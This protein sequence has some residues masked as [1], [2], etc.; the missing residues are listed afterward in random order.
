MLSCRHSFSGRWLRFHQT[1][2]DVCQ[3]DQLRSVAQCGQHTALVPFARLRLASTR[4]ERALNLTSVLSLPSARYLSRQAATRAIPS[5]LCPTPRSSQ[6]HS[7]MADSAA[8]LRRST[9]RLRAP[10]ES[11]TLAAS[12]HESDLR[13]ERRR[14][15]GSAATSERLSNSEQDGEENEEA[16]DDTPSKRAL[17]EEFE[18][19]E[20]AQE[21]AQDDSVPP[22]L[23]PA[24]AAASLSSASSLDAS[25]IRIP[26]PAHRYSP[27]KAQWQ[28]L[29]QPVV[30]HMKLQI[31]FNPK[32]RCIELRVRH[33]TQHST[34][35]HTASGLCDATIISC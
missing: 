5:L 33:T 18:M 27:L 4:P 16:V 17:E 6:P 25:Y 21:E 13:V 10:V 15:R 7:V 19:K 8:P 14:K 3:I 9:K 26:V 20:E 23:F 35:Q 2:P 31:R 30:E 24:T 32:K 11:Q 28:A 12:S 34:A 22:A 1:L 29:Y